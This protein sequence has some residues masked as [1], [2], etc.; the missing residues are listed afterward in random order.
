[1]KKIFPLQKILLN[2]KNKYVRQIKLDMREDNKKMI[3]RFQNIYSSVAESI[4]ETS[5]FYFEGIK[6]KTRSEKLFLKDIRMDALKL[7]PILLLLVLPGSTLILPV[8]AYLFPIILPKTLHT[9]SYKV[10][11]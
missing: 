9:P 3:S 10:K 5:R 4:K 2:E 8:V 1:M 6:F 7:I 11:H